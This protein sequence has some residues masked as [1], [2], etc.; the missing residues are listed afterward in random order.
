MTKI[1]EISRWHCLSLLTVHAQIPYKVT[2]SRLFFFFPD[3]GLL[4]IVWSFVSKLHIHTAAGCISQ[5]FQLPAPKTLFTHAYY[6]WDYTKPW[7]ATW[8]KKIGQIAVIRGRVQTEKCSCLQFTSHFYSLYPLF[9][10]ACSLP[11][12]L[13]PSPFLPLLP[14][15]KR[16]KT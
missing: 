5:Y 6:D 4:F 16:V 10:H 8:F 15:N 7:F 12:H 14:L 2:G 9:S 11:T 1:H 13:D 3:M